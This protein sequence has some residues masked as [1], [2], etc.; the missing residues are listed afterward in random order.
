MAEYTRV[1]RLLRL[2]TLIQGGTGWTPERLAEE[3][4]V[5]VRTIYRDLKELEGAGIGIEFDRSAK[6]YR[7][8][9]DFFLPPVQ[10]TAREALSLSVLCE[11]VA[12]REQIPFIRPAVQADGG[13]VE[14][15][16]VTDEGL[17]RVRFHGACVGCPSA[18]MTLKTGIE[19]SLRE[20]VPEVTGVEAVE[21]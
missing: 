13:D 7:L 10:L 15:V 2:L 8:P 21:D 6:T 16:E 3:C 9:Q 20:R 14:L 17:V 18:T 5:S 4:E 19:H 11:Q 12:Q 1:H